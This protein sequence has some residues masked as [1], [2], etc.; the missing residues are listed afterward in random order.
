MV[1]PEIVVVYNT[2]HLLAQ[3][4]NTKPWHRQNYLLELVAEWKVTSWTHITNYRSPLHSITALSLLTSDNELTLVFHSSSLV[5]G[6]ASV[7]SVVVGCQVGDSQWAGEVDV[8][9]SHTEADGDRPAIFL[10]SDVQWPV[11]WHDH[12]GDED[13]LS[14][15]KTLELKWLN[16]RRHCRS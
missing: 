5:A 15:G 4:P 9:H 12:A 1:I 2:D 6:N 3:Q 10:P 8:V 13:T 14:N 7:V 16:V 11:A